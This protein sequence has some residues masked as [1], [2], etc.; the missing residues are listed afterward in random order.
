M[1]TSSP[2]LVAANGYAQRGWPVFPVHSV[3]AGRCSCCAQ[4]CDSPGKHPRTQHGFKDATTD[5]AVIR[6]WW[7]KWPSANVA[8]VTG[9]ESGLFVLDIDKGH[10]GCETL[11]ALISKNGAL[12]STPQARSG[13]GGSHVYFKHPGH[14]V[15]NRAK[16]AGGID[17]RGDGGYIV[18]PPS[19]H[20]SGQSYS[21]LEGCS[22]AECALALAPAWVLD[23]LAPKA[24]ESA[25]RDVGE[26]AI[27]EGERNSSLTKLAGRL[28]KAGASDAAM[29]AALSVTN[30]ASCKP[31]LS[32]EEVQQIAASVSRYPQGGLV[33]SAVLTPMSGVTRERLVWLWPWRIP[34]GKLTVLS[35]DPGLGKSMLTIDI[36]ARVTTGAGW[37]DAPE[38]KSVPAGAI[39][40]SAEDDPADTI[41]P[42]LDAAGADS[43]RVHLLQAVR[44]GDAETGFNLAVDIPVLEAALQ[45]HPDTRVLVID[46]VTA[47]LGAT[48]SHVNSDVR[49]LL[50][51]LSA[52]AAKY[53]VAIVLVSHLNKSAVGPAIYRTTGS[54][55]FVAAARSGLVVVKDPS[56]PE[57]KRRFLVSLKANLGPG[58]SGLI[59]RVDGV[60]GSDAARIVWEPGSVD[61]TADELLNQ[62]G[63]ASEPKSKL[64]QA[65][66]FLE[67]ALAL[68]PL[69]AAEVERR[70]TAKGISPITLR[71]AAKAL[72]IEK[73][74]AGFDGGWSWELPEEGEAAQPPGAQDVSTFGPNEHL[75]KPVE[76][77]TQVSMGAAV[78]KVLK[79]AEGAHMAEAGAGDHLPAGVSPEVPLR[80][81]FE[82]RAAI[83]E[84]EAGFPRAQAESLAAQAE[85]AGR[86]TCANARSALG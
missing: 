23:L 66:L 37:P 62:G 48:D 8:I 54:L 10:G 82:E 58:V 59:F 12:P 15:V 16:V 78:P 4:A 57:G 20:A 27:P 21:W 52:L 76:G 65:A 14:A 49:A 32:D 46:P 26:R 7:A 9:K 6:E 25:G 70:A 77:D 45:A 86:D 41:G 31:P 44:E 75:R 81:T 33:R 55:A 61:A 5:E 73:R 71:R 19:L 79:N 84:F 80:E 68:G 35:S 36:I 47:Y 22:P 64:E 43:T 74:K 51:P 83:L 24:K 28:R 13:G 3:E 85:H 50:A 53:R 17:V 11:A 29:T 60:T 34:L 56:D 63:W 2:Q 38:A 67:N 72:G 40:L 1:S 39:L 30:R 42:R 18:A 69:D